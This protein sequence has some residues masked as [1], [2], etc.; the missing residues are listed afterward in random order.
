MAGAS[1]RRSPKWPMP[2]AHSRRCSDELG[3]WL[4]AMGVLA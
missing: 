4:L 1:R 3:E 2:T